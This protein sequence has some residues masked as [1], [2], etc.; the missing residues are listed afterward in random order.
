[1]VNESEFETGGMVNGIGYHD[2]SIENV[3]DTSA[4]RRYQEELRNEETKLVLLKKIRHSH[5][6]RLVNNSIAKHSSSSSSVLMSQSLS[7]PP[8]LVQG[9]FQ[10]STT[11]SHRTSVHQ[12]SADMPR[13]HM[14][15]GA[16]GAHTQSA[17]HSA[18]GPPPLL[19]APRQSSVVTSANRSTSSK[20][21]STHEPC[22]TW[23]NS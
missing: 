17:H 7:G 22:V 23:S 5:V 9:G 15:V 18:R 4:I 19:M 3:A 14:Q 2:D 13:L 11:A 8:P 6:H 20:T 12:S 16:S 1:M 21:L 10:S